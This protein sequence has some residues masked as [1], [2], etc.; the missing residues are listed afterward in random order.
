[1][2]ALM[3]GMPPAPGRFSTT[4][5]CFQPCDSLSAIKRE[6]ISGAVPG[7]NGT[8]RWTGLEGQL[9]A[10]APV[11]TAASAA[12]TVNVLSRFTYNAPLSVHHFIDQPARRDNPAS[13]FTG[14]G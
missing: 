10:S 1:M 9:C 6:A 8:S 7:G 4:I 3:P 11:A 12:A 2:K 14:E 5:C 13:E